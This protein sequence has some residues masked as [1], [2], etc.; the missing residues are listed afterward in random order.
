MLARVLSGW[1]R[2][3]ALSVLVVVVSRGPM[4]SYKMLAK[5]NLGVLLGYAEECCLI[6]TSLDMCM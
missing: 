1:Q 5:D 4:L 3:A 6:V 2:V